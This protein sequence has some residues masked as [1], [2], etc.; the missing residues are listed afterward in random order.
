MRMKG[1]GD[2]DSSVS[3][4]R[5]SQS[6]FLVVFALAFG[7][8]YSQS[9]LYTS[10]QNQYFLH[11][12][13]RSGVGYL[14]N[15][16]LARTADPTPVFS[17]FVTFIYN[18]FQFKEIFY[19]AYLFLLAVYFLCCLGIARELA[20][21]DQPTEV[22]LFIVLFIFIHSSA[23]RFLIT[24]VTSP[25]WGYFFE[26]GLAGQRV[27]GTVLQPSSFGILLILSIY[28]YL[29]R[30]Y[31]LSVV[32]AGLAEVFHP[33][34]LLPAAMIILAIVWGVY[35]EGKRVKQAAL[36]GVIGV[37]LTLMVAAYVLFT[38]RP[39]SPE[40]YARAQEILVN[41]RIPH[42]ALISEWLNVSSFFQL[43][44][45]FLAA[46]LIRNRRLFPI[47]V[48]GISAGLFISLLQILTDSNMVALLFP[49]RISSILI[50]LSTTILLAILIELLF[51]HQRGWIESHFAVL[52]I[53][54]SLVILLTGVA[55]IYY[56][57]QEYRDKLFSKESEL[58]RYVEMNKQAEDVYL[59]PI[60][61]QDFR[62][63]T[64]GAAYVDFK[65][66]PYQDQE[67]IEWHRRVLRASDFYRRKR[68]NC[69]DLKDWIQAEEITQL[70]LTNDQKEPDCA[71]LQET[72][73]NDNY[74]LFKFSP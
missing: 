6:I 36:L 69:Q 8:S 51:R 19:L 60:D 57:V 39:T 25:D 11:G 10:N 4:L 15:D 38:F 2:R 71:F 47:F 46:Y 72:F 50:P 64:G 66:I 20:E 33:T 58:Y 40:E 5:R 18:I 22:F 54:G 24:K 61:M 56:F 63:A 55:G 44:L 14:Q 74:R 35:Q 45:V 49:W 53:S 43:F 52:I 26:G 34:Y 29:I 9:P 37:V 16:W 1:S 67:V 73:R 59:T 68:I 42:H 30:K 3:L 70:I 41:F 17:Y 27:L 65:S 7:I 21:I 62:L 13:A 31:I 32:V 12:L 23:F 28:L 48:I